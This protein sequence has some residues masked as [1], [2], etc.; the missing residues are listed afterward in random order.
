[1]RKALFLLLLLSVAYG[2]YAQRYDTIYNP[3]SVE[4]IPFYE[5][6]YRWRVWR[7]I[8]LL[9]KQNAGFKSAK[10]DIGAFLIKAIQSG[11]IIAYDGDSIK[12]PKTPGEVMVINQAVM[13][14]A[15]NPNQEYQA[16]DQVSYQGKNYVTNR[17][18]NKG[19]LPTDAQ[20]W[21][22]G[23]DQTDL[24]QP[25]SIKELQIVEDVIFDKRRSRLYYDI[26]AIGIIAEKDGT[27]NPRGYYKDFYNLVEKMAHSKDLDVRDK[28]Q[29]RNRYN[30]SEGKT[31]TDAF[32][33]RL[34]HGVIEKVENPDDWTIQ[35]IYEENG[36][37]YG[38]SVF[39]RWEKEMEMMEK[40][41][42]LWEY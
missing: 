4:K 17:N 5:Q 37:T 1:M 22:L 38:E 11:S 3:N 26:I 27:Y 21:E 10:S 33:L 23:Q 16:G 20:W 36:R 12:N 18:S 19:N 25:S 13:A 24:L 9:E 15:Y 35:R 41:H 14:A 28:V 31:F 2:S 6:L 32:K 42:N 39:A 30:P 7:N 29:W 34:F 8:N 40:E